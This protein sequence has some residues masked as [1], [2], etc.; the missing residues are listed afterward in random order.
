MMW[1][2][3]QHD[4]PDVYVISSGATHSIREF[5][6]EAGRICG[7]DIHWEGSDENETGIDRKTGKTLVKVN[8]KYYRPAEVELLLGKSEKAQKVLN[9]HTKVD[10]KSLCRMM[11]EADIARIQAQRNRQIP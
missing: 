5:V 4:S 6:D 9:W 1:K 11:T 7:F 3:L 8:S 2:M 10:F